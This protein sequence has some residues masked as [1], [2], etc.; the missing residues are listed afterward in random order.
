MKKTRILLEQIAL[1]MVLSLVLTA[2]QVPDASQD[3]IPSSVI[4][5]ESQASA[6]AFDEVVEESGEVV[7]EASDEATDVSE[8]VDDDAEVVGAEA[9]DDET[10]EPVV[11][12]DDKE[13]SSPVVAKPAIPAWIKYVLDVEEYKN[14]HPDLQRAFGNDTTA[15]VN[16][17]LTIG[18]REGRTK[19]VLFDPIAYAA[20]YPDIAAVYGNDINGIIEHYVAI[21][22]NEGRTQGTAAGFRDIEAR[23]QFAAS[24]YPT[25]GGSSAP[26]ATAVPTAAP[27]VVPTE[28]PT[29]P[30]VE[31]TEPPVPPTEVPS[32]TSPVSTPAPTDAPSIEPP[33]PEPTAEPTP[34]PTAEPTPAPTAEPTPA[35]TAEP[36]PAPTA[37]P[38]AEPAGIVIIDDNFDARI[39]NAQ[40]H[41]DGDNWT[42][43]WDTKNGYC[44][45]DVRVV[46]KSLFD[47]TAASGDKVLRINPEDYS[48]QEH[49]QI[50]LVWTLHVVEEKWL[51]LGSTTTSDRYLVYELDLTAYGDEAFEEDFE[52]SLRGNGD[53]AIATFKMNSERMGRVMNDGTVTALRDDNKN[54]YTNGT[55]GQLK[56]VLDRETKTYS[57]YWNGTLVESDV[58]ALCGGAE[59]TPALKS[60]R[61]TMPCQPIYSFDTILTLDNMKLYAED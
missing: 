51:P 9:V 57:W 54:A 5:G 28:L 31:P 48:E 2:C 61:Y 20:A 8:S 44:T 12:K 23:N 21:G 42:S 11:D 6:E 45:V 40:E 29:V 30:P 58:A 36:T 26:A 24:N 14:G 13:V 56:W 34:A 41:F 37:E 59:E 39:N 15:Y 16:H 60:I 35:P 7:E 47:A 3:V 38:T 32:P 18:V 27:T 52:I 22:K 49:L 25:G 53:N 46:N 1:M 43:S 33:T 4:V 50:D 17:W 19:G 55:T 10:E